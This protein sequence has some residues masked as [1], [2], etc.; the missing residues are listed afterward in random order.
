MKVKLPD[1]LKG[2]HFRRLHGFAI[3]NFDAEMLLPALFYVIATD[4]RGL[5]KRLTE[6]SPGE[7]TRKLAQHRRIV[8][9]EGAQR[10][11]VLDKW[12]RTSLISVARTGRSR[13]GGEQILYLKPLSFLTF[14]PGFPVQRTRLR[15]VHEFLYRTLKWRASGAGESA[16]SDMGRRVRQAFNQGVQLKTEQ[17]GSGYDGQYDGRTS[18]DTEAMLCL[19][20]LDGF[21]KA[22]PSLH[23]VAEGEAPTC[24]AGGAILA[25]DFLGF[26]RAYSASVPASV[27]ARY[28]VCL[29]NFELLIYTLKLATAAN[30][31][32]RARLLPQEMRPLAQAD[33]VPTAAL[34]F[35]VD[36]TGVGTSTSSRLAQTAF[37]RHLEQFERFLEA[38]LTLKTL[39]S[40]SGAAPALHGPRRTKGEYLHALLSLTGNVKVE[41]ACYNRM[42]DIEAGNDDDAQVKEFIANLREDP[43]LSDLG[44]LV[45]VLVEANRGEVLGN[46][47]KWIRDVGGISR[48]DGLLSGRT[49]G[50][51]RNWRYFLSDSLLET[52]VQLHFA[53]GAGGPSGGAADTRSTT[54][55]D[56]LQQLDDRYGILIAA[57]PESSDSAETRIAARENLIALRARLRQ[58][59]LFAD[60]SDDF[61]SQQLRPRYPVEPMTALVRRD[62]R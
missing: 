45:Q 51:R 41:A 6:I 26:I 42:I 60:L 7:Y 15:E 32:V 5:G 47:A 25:D 12:V 61:N 23:S 30:E 40:Y 29:I 10:E 62:A 54:I 55:S 20:Y 52:L 58:M 36:C 59:G 34:K 2:F 11:R 1:A 21:D 48:G 17:D 44:R 43:S 28:L 14:K 4:G 49:R 35:Y 37:W 56:F 38:V 27:L 57:P 3:N 50:Q 46:C 13:K 39:D 9:L 24:E 16:V 31:L 18:L 22:Y 33:V 53:I 19:H 8:G